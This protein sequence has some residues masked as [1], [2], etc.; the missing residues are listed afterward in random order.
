MSVD[1]ERWDQQAETSPVKS[2]VKAGLERFCL[3]RTE[4]T[5]EVHVVEVHADWF[6]WKR[7]RFLFTSLSACVCNKSIDVQEGVGCSESRWEYG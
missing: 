6:G 1:D 7:K 4:G 5:S 3:S 2:G